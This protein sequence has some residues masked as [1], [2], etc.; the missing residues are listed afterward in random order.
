MVKSKSDG[1]RFHGAV[2]RQWRVGT[3]G[4]SESVFPP[5][6]RIRRHSHAHPYFSIL[7]HGSYRETYS[8]GVRECGPA[9]AVLHPPGEEHADRF[10]DAGGRIFRFEITDRESDFELAR[11]AWDRAELRNGRVRGLAARLYRESCTPDRFSPLAAEALAFEIISEATRD[12]SLSDKCGAP[13][14][15]SRAT[16]LLHEALPENLTVQSM[17][18]VVGVHP[19]HLARVF[20][21]RYGCNIGEYARN[22]RVEVASRQ[23]AAGTQPIAEV[24]A[25]AGFAD[26]SHLC[27][28]F[29]AVSGLTPKEFRAIFRRR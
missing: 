19:V 28:T 4:F 6:A 14:W 8:A 20:R 15:L 22:W 2:I 12:R 21:R 9:T 10:H 24:A 29:K 5:G 3:L 18:N 23:L 13:R 26:Q 7:L 25:V 16:E 11:A 17:A 1:E 27:R